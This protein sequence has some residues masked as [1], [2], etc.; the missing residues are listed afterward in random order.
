MIDFAFD[1]WTPEVPLTKSGIIPEKNREK[2]RADVT[3]NAGFHDCVIG[4]KGEA[5]LVAKSISFGS[6]E[7]MEFNSVYK[8]VFNVCWRLIL[9]NIEGMTEQA[10]ENAISQILSFD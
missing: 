9:K 5:R 10:A 3:I 6:M 1:Y 4:I 2:F 7:E 8:A